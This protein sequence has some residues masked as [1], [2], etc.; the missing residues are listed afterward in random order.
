MLRFLFKNHK[1][2]SFMWVYMCSCRLVRYKHLLLSG[3]P[4]S[5]RSFLQKSMLCGNT[6]TCH[7][8]MWLS[9]S[10]MQAFLPSLSW[11]TV[12]DMVHPTLVQI[13]TLMSSTETRTSTRLIHFGP[14]LSEIY[15]DPWPHWG[16]RRTTDLYF[17]DGPGFLLFSKKFLP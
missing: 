9:V 3:E 13:W 11:L 16:S 5:L 15:L 14:K 7:F 1:K 8:Q 17:T 6:G 10:C 12:Y 4:P 2:E